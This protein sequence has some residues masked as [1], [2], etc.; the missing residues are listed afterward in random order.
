MLVYYNNL[1]YHINIQQLNYIDTITAYT[2]PYWL[3]TH[4]SATLHKKRALH[5]ESLLPAWLVALCVLDG[6]VVL[7]EGLVPTPPREL[8]A[9]VPTSSKDA[10]KDHTCGD[11]SANLSPQEITQPR[12]WARHGRLQLNTR[13]S[14]CLRVEERGHGTN[15]FIA[16]SI[17]GGYQLS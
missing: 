4:Q 2:V 11:I 7:V 5:V 15:T 6:V 17:D 8:D 12:D 1:M 13:I 10:A 3:G 14:V 9:V 16:N